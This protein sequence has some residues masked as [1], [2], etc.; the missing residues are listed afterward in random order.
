MN[1]VASGIPPPPEYDEPLR[2]Y[3]F[4]HMIHAYWINTFGTCCTVEANK[5]LISK[6]RGSTQN[7]KQISSKPQTNYNRTRIQVFYSI[8][9]FMSSSSEGLKPGQDTSG[10]SE[11]LNLAVPHEEMTEMLATLHYRRSQTIHLHHLHG[12]STKL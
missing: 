10:F 8:L 1:D 2:L 7:F 9:D 4:V 11:V 5:F 3:G 6:D 12:F